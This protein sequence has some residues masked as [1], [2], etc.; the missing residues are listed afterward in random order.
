[1]SFCSTGFVRIDGADFWQWVAQATYDS[2]QLYAPTIDFSDQTL[3]LT[4]ESNNTID[5]DG[6]AF[7]EFVLR[8]SPIPPDTHYLFGKPVFENNQVQVQFVC[9]TEDPE[10]APTL[11]QHLAQI[12]ASWQA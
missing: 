11:A 5:I 10:F 6:V 4:T 3:L 9:S 12:K 8:Y 1:M 2:D 7:W